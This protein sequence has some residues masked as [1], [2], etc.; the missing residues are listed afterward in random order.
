MYDL[1]F[2]KFLSTVNDAKPLINQD[3]FRTVTITIPRRR[4]Q[5]SSLATNS[6]FVTLPSMN[7]SNEI[8][9]Y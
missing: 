7:V 3:S 5:H 2:E 8:A 4:K 9:T 6:L 1:R